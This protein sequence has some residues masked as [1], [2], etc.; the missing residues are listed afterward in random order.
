MERCTSPKS[1]QQ[2][3]ARIAGA[4]RAGL[5]WRPLRW[6][7]APGRRCR[8]TP[9]IPGARAAIRSRHHTMIGRIAGTL[10]EKNPPHLLVDCHGVGYEI[11]VPMST[12]YNLPAVGH[13]VTLLTQ[14][15]VRE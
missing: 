15:I 8:R 10:I 7:G 1:S 3:G 9:L 4:P 2:S 5:H 11:D 6:R 12:F 14:Q 13:P